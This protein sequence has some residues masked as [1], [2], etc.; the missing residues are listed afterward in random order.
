MDYEFQILIHPCGDTSVL[1]EITE[2]E[3]TLINEAIENNESFRDV[4]ALSDLYDRV[5][6]AARQQIEE[7]LDLGNEL[8]IDPDDLDYCVEF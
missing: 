3:A 4:E 6:D 7:D 5:M 2:E 1:Y 8:G